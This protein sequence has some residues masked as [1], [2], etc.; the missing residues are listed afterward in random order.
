MSGSRGSAPACTSR[1]CSTSTSRG[2][3]PSGRA[4]TASADA[5]HGAG[6]VDVH[7]VAAGQQQR[8]DDGRPARRPRARPRRRRRWAAGRRR[9]P[10]SS[11]GPAAARGRRGPARRS[12]A[13]RWGCGCRARRRPA[14]GAS[15]HSARSD[16]AVDGD[17]R[18]GQ[19]G[20][21]GGEREGGHP[22]ELLG[23]AHPAQRDRR[24]RCG[25]ARPPASPEAASISVIRSVA[26][27]PGSSPNTR[28]PARAQLVGQRLRRHRQARGAG[29]WRSPGGRSARGPSG[30]DEADRGALAEV[31]HQ[32][33]DQP[34]RA[35]QHALERRPPVLLAG[36]E[37]RAGGGAADADQRAVDPA[38]PLPRLGDQLLGGVGVGQVGG[39]AVRGRARRR[40]R[41]PRRRP[42]RRSGS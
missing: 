35:E 12:A 25:R 40:A 19:V 24:P 28:M 17:H 32:R 4:A 2:S 26:I 18:A 31:R 39:E 22:A 38:Q 8:D 20:G 11:P 13:V 27:V 37:H 30:E 7:V 16:A 1:S 6:D 36:L 33:L 14:P 10:P 23:P 21:G 9:R 34:Q 42:R 29:R 5:G 41:R 3:G 15:A